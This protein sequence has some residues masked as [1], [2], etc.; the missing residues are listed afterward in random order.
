MARGRSR[1]FGLDTTTW[2]V[3]HKALAELR[4]TSTRD[5]LALGPSQYQE[6]VSQRIVLLETVNKL[7]GLWHD[8]LDR[9][10]LRA[11]VYRSGRKWEFS[12]WRAGACIQHGELGIEDAASEED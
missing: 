11:C 8:E 6:R 5:S 4:A 10:V 2:D 3:L 9:P 7:L 12:A 1:E